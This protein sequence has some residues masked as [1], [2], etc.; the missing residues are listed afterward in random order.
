AARCQPPSRRTWRA[1][2]RSPRRSGS[3]SAI[4]AKR[5]SG[6]SHSATG[7]ARWPTIG[8]YR[9]NRCMPEV[10]V[11]ALEPTDVEA[12][13]AIFD[14]PGVV[15]GTLQMPYRSLEFQ[16]G[17]LASADTANTHFL[18][19]VVD[20]RVVGMLGL[21]L[22]TNARRRDCASFGMAVHD[23]FQNKGVGKALM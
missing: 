10:R 4:S 2:P 14:S 9:A 21:H 3:P 17:R 5:S 15:R 18:V 20:E 19:A 8:C 7:T 12:I 13:H 1:E 11:R 22:E 16:R 6:P 23:A